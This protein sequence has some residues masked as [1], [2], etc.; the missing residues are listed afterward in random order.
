MVKQ[1]DEDIKKYKE[2]LKKAVNKI[3]ELDKDL[4]KMKEEVVVI[5]YSCRFPKGANNP[6]DY[7]RLLCEGYDGVTTINKERFDVE[8]YYSNTAGEEG[9]MITK[10]ASL[11]D[12]D[13]KSFDNVHFEISE[14]EATSMDPQHRLLLEVS[15]EALENSGI[16]FEELKGS[17]TGVFL[18]IDASE[19]FQAETYTSDMRNITP[20]SIMGVSSHSAAG[21]I[22]YHYDLKGP[23]VVCNTACSSSLTALNYAVESLRN[24]Q[25]DM[26]IVGGVNLLIS[27]VSF[28]GLSQFNALAPDGK[29]KTFDATADGFGRGEGCGVVILKRLSD[30]KLDG[31][32]IEA[33]IKGICIGQDGKSNGFFAP[34]GEAEARVIKEAIKCSGMSIDNIDYIE[35]HGTGTVLG[36]LIETQAINDVFKRKKGKVKIGS[37]KS[38]IG[39]LEAASGMAGL[40][41]ILLS[42][43]YKKLPPSINI[44]TVNPAIDWD[45][46]ECV[47]CLCDWETGTGARSA[48]ISSFGI[49]GTLAHVIIKEPD[50]DIEAEVLSKD[51]KPYSIVTLSAKSKSSLMAYISQTK[52]NIADSVYELN[53]IAYSANIT[54]SSMRYKYAFIGNSKEN[55]CSEMEKV[56]QDKG[57][58]ETIESMKDSASCK[59]RIV[60]L[61]TGQ[62]SIYKDIGKQLYEYEVEFQ[63]I[64]D[65]C[66]SAFQK[67]LGISVLNTIYG[68]EEK[69]ISDP[70]YSQPVIFSVEY[71]LAKTWEALGV[72]PNV[73]IGHS[74]GEYAAACYA[75]YVDFVNAVKMIGIRAKLMSNMEADGKM[76]GILTDEE[77]IRRILEEHHFTDVS[78][79]A[80]NAPKNVTVSGTV[81]EIE[82]F[83]AI[84]QKE[85]R[86]FIN[87][88]GIQKPYHSIIMEKYED[89]YA[90]MLEDIYFEQGSIAM[91]STVTGTNIRGS[92]MGNVKYWQR[93]LSKTVR[94]QEAICEAYKDG[95]NMFIE[96]GGNA[97]L[98]GLA[99][100]CIA[101]DSITL[102]PTLRKATDDYL[103]L[104]QALKTLY[105]NGV[106]INWKKLYEPMKKEKT[107]LE[108]YPFNRKL[109]YKE[110]SCANM[111]VISANT[112]VE[113][114]C[115]KE[116]EIQ[117]VISAINSIELD[118]NAME[119]ID[120]IFENQLEILE[121]QNQIISMVNNKRGN[122]KHGYR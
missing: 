91:I 78:I 17:K 101:D 13:F 99:G 43:K 7:W 113:K 84:L 45:K 25:C 76:A 49:S 52:K 57:T 73:V 112:D 96:I 77:L 9:K 105:M 100:Q 50:I 54:K 81:E 55:I 12:I 120:I 51:C 92:E 83:I 114:N 38:N 115:A 122:G 117:D 111:T 2:A 59:N 80:V 109:L 64:M 10:Y 103:Q 56:I 53:D 75:G 28:I 24:G 36:D 121:Q 40:I 29:C 97:T 93:H 39:H 72:K 26:A 118:E 33:V 46:I 79:A 34:N 14:T 108:T 102:L 22:A 95:A 20:Y 110:L 4:K 88:L 44:Q 82:R 116:Q 5:G 58:E 3:T 74:I 37:V 27:P 60:F 89:E 21:R 94:Y 48:G 42:L 15:F 23:A 6:D 31:D 87:D 61:F 47:R 65:E 71:A 119:D 107:V 90:D 69:L 18:G 104:L 86:V 1:M 11:L 98:T 30:A 106:K 66:D 19:Y 62:G 70:L 85:N 35:A 41:K 63:R 68:D 16:D 32:S 8:Q 67:Q